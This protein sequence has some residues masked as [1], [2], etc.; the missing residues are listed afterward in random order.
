MIFNEGINRLL[1]LLFIFSHHMT[2]LQHTCMS[3]LSMSIF[4]ICHPHFALF[5]HIE[6]LA[7]E[8]ICVEQELVLPRARRGA[9]A[10]AAPGGAAVRG[11]ATGVRLCPEGAVELTPNPSKQGRHLKHHAKQIVSHSSV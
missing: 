6:P 4:Y 10:P 11:A 1:A 8:A 2:S 7:E 9:R 5:M 3:N